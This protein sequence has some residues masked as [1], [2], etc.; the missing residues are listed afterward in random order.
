MPGKRRPPHPWAG[1]PCPPDDLFDVL[2]GLLRGEDAAVARLISMRPGAIEAI[3]V[4]LARHRVGPF[5]QHRLRDSPVTQA[6]PA[7]VREQIRARH[8]RQVEIAQGCLG[9]LEMFDREC[10][11]AAIPF[12][13]LKGPAMAQRLY[14]DV[15]GRGFWDLDILVAEHDRARMFH[16][17][18]R[19]GCFRLSTVFV[20]DR[21]SAAFTHAF[22]YEKD[23]VRLDLHWSLSR[24]PGLRCEV[25]G[26]MARRQQFEVGGVSAPVLCMEDELA[27]LLVSVFADIQRGSVRLQS[28]VDVWQLLRRTPVTD[29]SRFIANRVS[30]GS[31]RIC[32]D[33]LRVTLGALDLGGEFPELVDRLGGCPPTGE[34]RSLLLSSSGGIR[35][36]AW[37]A[38][39]LP[40]SLPRYAAW[41]LLSLPFRVAASHPAWR[42][43]LPPSGSPTQR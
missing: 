19:C 32:A 24:L 7:E 9:L 11:A 33:T 17:L 39:R 5:L 3:Q 23:G 36:K 20:S 13:L 27:F 38:Q 15:A 34:A 8:R 14:G 31:D 42:R 21:L 16:L 18:D 10:H 41:W 1:L 35:R 29:W 43:P 30:E 40:V 6:L 26:V 12:L 22:D 25:A 37:A 2:G 4:L 28:F